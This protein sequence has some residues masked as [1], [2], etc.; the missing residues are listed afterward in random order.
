M[1]DSNKTRYKMKYS[2]VKLF[3]LSTVLLL[4]GCGGGS[5][6]SDTSS[7]VPPSANSLPTGGTPSAVSS[8]ANP[9]PTIGTPS[10]SNT[11]FIPAP[12]NSRPVANKKS[13]SVNSGSNMDITL[14]GT[15]ADGDVLSYNIVSQPLYGTLSGTAP[16][17]TYASQ[18][19]Y[20]GL[21]SFTYLVNDG[22]EDSK[23]VKVLIDVQKHLLSSVKVT[24][25]VTYDHVPSNSDHVG[26]DYQNITSKSAKQVLVEAVNGQGK[27]FASASTDEKGAYTLTLPQN[28]DLKI[29]VRA[30]MRRADSVIWDVKVVDNTNS[31]ALY[32][33]EG[34][35]GSTGNSDSV[36]NLHAASGWGGNSYT[37][38]RVAAPFAILDTVYSAMQK[39]FTVDTHAVFFPLTVNWSIHNRAASGD[40]K[41]GDIGTS[42]YSH[43]N[44]FI[45]GDEDSDTDEY[46]DH[47]IAHEWG[48]YYEDTF[49]R[50]DSIGGSHGSDDKLDIHVAFS[51]GWGN[52]FSAM[53]LDEPVY[54]DTYGEDQGKGYYFDVESG[55]NSNKGWYSE[56]SIQRILYDL[57]DSQN[58]GSDTLSLGF[59]PIHTVFTGPERST[60]V[61]TNIFSCITYMKNENPA[62]A[63]QIDAIVSSEDIA[64]ITDVFGNGRT[65]LANQMPIYVDLTVG[66]SITV[67]PSYIYGKYNKLGNRKYIRFNINNMGN[68][69]VSVKKSN[70]AGL[71]DPDFYIHNVFDHRVVDEGEDGDADIETDTVSLEEAS[72]LLD[73]YDYNNISGACFDISVEEIK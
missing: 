42:Y 20:N 36:R 31:D 40:P 18:A 56:S 38:S 30:Q 19:T 55:T 70:S 21:D 35:L 52:A 64:Q 23:T 48:H 14:S 60:P 51:E 62:N 65:N 46:D 50:L 4:N 54:F 33:M 6:V 43:G 2:G 68:Y 28:T 63:E 59:A 58:D 13:V 39:I 25:T 69:K 53:A 29:R 37:S 17:L 72:Y 5:T 3:L 61:L 32:V 49:S 8:S 7:A 12:A 44:L 24:G 73:M 11:N 66:N 9:V 41:N 22:R 10:S 57:Y 34:S 45:L 16:S 27:P 15:D 26:L 67:C 47:V 1:I 71:T